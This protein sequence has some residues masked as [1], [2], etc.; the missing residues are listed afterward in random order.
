METSEKIITFDTLELLEEAILKDV[1]S[2]D[3]L[4]QR[5]CVR[6]IMLNS[7]DAFRK[8]TVF[9]N[10][11]VKVCIVNLEDKPLGPDKTIPIDTL[12]EVVKGIDKTSLVTPFSELVRFYPD[13]QFTGFFNEIILTEDI[14]NPGKRIYIPIIGLQNRFNDFIKN[15]G[16]VE[17]SAPIWRYNAPQDDRVMVYVSKFKDFEIP[18]HLNIC[19]LSTMRDW[20]MFWKQQA[21]KDKILCG[22]MPIRVGWKN[23]RPD[24][25]FSFHQV[26]NAYEFITEFL[27]IQVPIPYDEADDKYW[28]E[29]LNRINRNASSSFSFK[30][31]VEDYFNR[32]SLNAKDI[33]D[34]WASRDIEPFGR[35]L[36]KYYALSLNVLEHSPYL[37]LVLSELTD[38]KNG[39]S[40]FVNV[41]ERILYFPT[42]AER[43]RHFADRKNLMLTDGHHFRTLV[44]TD[45]Q[46]W[47]ED[48][49]VG[50][51][52]EDNNLVTAKKLCTSTFPFERRLFLGWFL[53]R[54]DQDFGLKHLEEYYPEMVGYMKPMAELDITPEVVW[55]KSYFDI[56]RNAKMLDTFTDKLKEAIAS[57]NQNADSF[58]GWFYKFNESHD[59]LNGLMSDASKAPDKV[60]WVDGL[61]AEFIPYILY[62]IE[63]S[64]RGYE[65]IHTEIA[66]TTIP[67]NTHLNGFKL[68]GSSFVKI[69]DLDDLAHEG[70]YKK[71][72][73]LISELDTI[74]RIVRR[75]LDE[76]K[77]GNHTVAIVSDHGLSSMSRKVDSLKLKSKTHHEGRYVSL[78]DNDSA[79]HD[80][81]FVIETNPRDRKRYMVALTHASLG[82]KPTHEVHGGATPEEVLV[83]FIVLTN[84]DNKKLQSFKIQPIEAKVP[85][86][87]K[88]VEF[89]IMP[90]PKSAELTLNGKKY[91]LTQ[92][93]MKWRAIV[94]DAKEGTFTTV[95]TPA[96][97]K[98]QSFK[99]EF[100]GMGFNSSSLLDD[101]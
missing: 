78:E 64:N 53:H 98:S 80:E 49:I 35:W 55:A 13:E 45:R 15:F 17:E 7:F 24:S 77:L 83:P 81:A 33:L 40:L 86:S 90:E 4:A 25:I 82:T 27:E 57:C 21:P 95:V 93:N 97:G 11:A 54:H 65:A 31:F 87:S 16:R 62:L 28:D 99:I 39:E 73:T 68:N 30:V 58:F 50:F 92:Q 96:K 101:F 46:A 85:V 51:A 2:K 18:S 84:N 56:F 69:S 100:Y 9:L 36:L 37:K 12:L 60:Y 26:D 34:L 32:K 88:A 74:E 41:A 94:D 52:Q 10:N 43:E 66:R 63:K 75:I 19:S 20:L 22:A 72:D 89:M 67:S 71:Y 8:L 1:S 48:K 44:P 42:Q 70:H 91:A 23:S 6:F 76:N 59:I 47:I 3:V 29:L 79:I 5:Y 38:L 14:K 61:G